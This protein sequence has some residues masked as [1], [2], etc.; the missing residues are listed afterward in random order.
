MEQVKELTQIVLRDLQVGLPASD[1]VVTYKPSDTENHVEVLVQ[2]Q[3]GMGVGFQVDA[4]QAKQAIL[5]DL[6]DRIP[7]A[8]VELFTVGLPVVPGTQRPAV[9]EIVSGVTVWVDPGGT[10]NW[11]CAVGEYQ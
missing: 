8:F 4:S 6:A 5:R 2:D 10:S 11:S 7:D 1:P 3:T 9:P